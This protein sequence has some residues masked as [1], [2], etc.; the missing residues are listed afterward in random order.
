MILDD[1]MASTFRISNLFSDDVNT[2]L[3]YDRRIRLPEVDKA[4]HAIRHADY[5]GF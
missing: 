2:W 5:T 1:P 4:M 3:D